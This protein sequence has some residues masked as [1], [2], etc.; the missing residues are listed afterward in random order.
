MSASLREKNKTLQNIFQH[1]RAESNFFDLLQIKCCVI[2]VNRGTA[3]L[4]RV[5]LIILHNFEK[6]YA[7]MAEMQKAASMASA[8]VLFFSTSCANFWSVHSCADIW[9]VHAQT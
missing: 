5:L 6:C 9:S 2:L 7:I 8:L 3:V 4:S 1:K